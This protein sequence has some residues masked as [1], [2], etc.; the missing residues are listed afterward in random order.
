VPKSLRASLRKRRRDAAKQGH[1]RNKSEAGST[2]HVNASH[3]QD[4]GIVDGVTSP[5]KK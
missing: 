4:L 5:A 2:A 3:L 1:K